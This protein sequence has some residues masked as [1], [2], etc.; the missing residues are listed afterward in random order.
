MVNPDVWLPDRDYKQNVFLRYDYTIAVHNKR[1]TVEDI[2]SVIMV[3]L[4]PFGMVPF[5]VNDPNFLLAMLGS[6][7][8]CCF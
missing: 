2:A 7:F 3:I 6:L 1:A 4:I 5:L 8:T